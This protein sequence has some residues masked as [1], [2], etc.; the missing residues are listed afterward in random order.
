MGACLR[1][2]LGNHLA[3]ACQLFILDLNFC[4]R[5]DG[6]RVVL[7]QPIK[8]GVVDHVLILLS[9]CLHL[10]TMDVVSLL[11]FIANTSTVDQIEELSKNQKAF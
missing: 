3:R 5:L 2:H 9:G 4:P 6:N 10:S 8:A 11:I 1:L 7:L